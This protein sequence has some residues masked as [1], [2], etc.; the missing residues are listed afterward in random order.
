MD[1]KNEKPR[2]SWR[3]ILVASSIYIAFGILAVALIS[4]PVAI[5]A[6]VI[7]IA[8]HALALGYGNRKTRKQQGQPA[9][10][11]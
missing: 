4:C 9:L 8:A 2:R 5:V 6:Y 1:D 11:Q 10:N 3:R 7:G